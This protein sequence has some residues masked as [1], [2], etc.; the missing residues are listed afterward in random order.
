M[1]HTRCILHVWIRHLLS[2]PLSTLGSSVTSIH[3][4][5]IIYNGPN[6]KVPWRQ[7]SWLFN[8]F[9]KMLPEVKRSC[10]LSTI[11]FL[12]FNCNIQIGVPIK[13]VEYHYLQ[14]RLEKMLKNLK[15]VSSS[16]ERWCELQLL[17]LEPGFSYC[18]LNT[19]LSE[20][21]WCKYSSIHNT[22][23]EHFY[24]IMHQI[25]IEIKHFI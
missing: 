13:K 15:A 8:M 21:I 22:T 20:L 1:N 11:S 14:V 7:D 16:K 2:C 9:I 10:V 18:M 24:R 19:V 4:L 12:R 6:W 5:C 3:V 25:F 17:Y 23:M